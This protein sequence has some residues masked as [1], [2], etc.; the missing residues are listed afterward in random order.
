VGPTSNPPI[1]VVFTVVT[2]AVTANETGLPAG[3]TWYFNVTGQ[4]GTS[5]LVTVGGG[6]ETAID[7]QNGS[8]S[9]SIATNWVNYSTS[10]PTGMLTVDGAPMN[11]TVRFTESTAPTYAVTFDEVSLSIGVTWYLNVTGEPGQ[12]TTVTATGGQSITLV[13]PN[14]SYSFAASTNQARWTWN[15][16]STGTTVLVAGAPLTVP[17]Y[18]QLPAVTLVYEVEFTETGLP[19]GY[20]FTV[21]VADRLVWTAAPSVLIFDLANGTYSYLVP[22]DVPYVANDSGGTLL[23][24]GHALTVAISFAS[25]PSSPGLSNA[26]WPWAVAD[27]GLI[28]LA[29]C[30]LVVVLRRRKKEEPPSTP[31]GPPDG[32]PGSGPAVPPGTGGASR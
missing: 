9:W 1:A 16:S 10:S 28:I 3:A 31:G 21:V 13:L 17:V 23:V 6:N 7:L 20:N 24:H 32:A 22:N 18:F 5:T 12:S 27:L 25:S 8:Y 2:F 26:A 30:G 29:L 15:A 19:L 11:I 14:G 4:P